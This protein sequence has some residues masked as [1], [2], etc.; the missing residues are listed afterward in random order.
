MKPFLI[1]V[2]T[3]FFILLPIN[4]EGSNQLKE[5]SL[6]KSCRNYPYNLG[7]NLKQMPGDS[8]RLLSTSLV[9]FKIDNSTFITRALREANL[10]AK[11]NMSSF[12]KL[13]EEFTGENIKD[14]SFPVRINGIIIK[15]NSQLK[16]KLRKRL[17]DSS[18]L[19]GVREIAKCNKESHYVKVTLEVTN[20]TMRAADYIG[21]YQ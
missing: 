19:K 18:S 20:E 14:I 15:T 10:R 6:L 3:G 4:T 5:Q 21:N 7:I 17:A 12:I 13:S 2:C 9:T 16:N 8:F 1:A 11:L